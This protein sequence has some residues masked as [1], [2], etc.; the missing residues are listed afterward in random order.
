MCTVCKYS[1]LREREG[2]YWRTKYDLNVHHSDLC[3]DYT[4]DGEVRDSW[5]LGPLPDAH[6]AWLSDEAELPRSNAELIAVFQ[7]VADALE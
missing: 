2:R 4:W 3:D 6:P 1:D 7:Q 5:V